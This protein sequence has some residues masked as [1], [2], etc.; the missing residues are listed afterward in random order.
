MQV[1]VPLAFLVVN[2]YPPEVGTPSCDPVDGKSGAFGESVAV[3]FD[4]RAEV[5]SVDM[6]YTESVGGETDGS[7]DS[8][9]VDLDT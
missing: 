1:N 8:L 4:V 2:Q 9:R 5:H 7:V 3:N 6:A